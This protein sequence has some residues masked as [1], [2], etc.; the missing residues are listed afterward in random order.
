MFRSPDHFISSFLLTGSFIFRS[1]IFNLSSNMKLHCQQFIIFIIG[2]VE[3]KLHYWCLIFGLRPRK[4]LNVRLEYLPFHVG[5]RTLGKVFTAVWWKELR[6]T[7]LVGY[8]LLQQLPNLII[9][10]E[11]RITLHALLAFVCMYTEQQEPSL[12]LTLDSTTII[13]FQILE[14][15]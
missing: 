12:P 6:L 5:W 4:F 1:S 10:F 3:T 7:A 14:N 9:L 8:R 11:L 13:V 2:L 15:I